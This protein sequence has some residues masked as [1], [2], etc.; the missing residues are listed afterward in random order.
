MAERARVV[1]AGGGI[2]GMEAALALREFA[3]E[4]A[5]VEIIDPAPSFTMPAT[6]PGRVVDL[7]AGGELPLDRVAEWAGATLHP[8]R[9]AAVDPGR[10]LAMLAGGE[11]LTYDVLVVATGA[12]AEPYIPDAITFTGHADVAKVRSLVDGI[13]HAAARGGRTDLAIVVPPGSAWPLAAYELAVLI[14]EHLVGLGHDSPG[15]TLVVTAEDGP[16]AVFGPEAS[17]AV[18]RWVDEAGVEV[19]TGAVVRSWRWGRIELAG[20]EPLQA[21]RMIALPVLRGPRLP[22]LPT[23][24]EGFVRSTPDGRIAG[25]EDVWVAGDA[26]SFPVKQGGIACQQA[27]AI[28]SAIARQLGAQ[29]EEVP[30]AP[31]LRGWVWDE[32]GG[33]F[34]RAELG[35]GRTESPGVAAGTPL[36]SPPAK[37]AGRFLAP[38]MRDLERGRPPGPAAQRPQ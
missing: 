13:A 11:L 25:V 7:V 21:D 15:R 1:I 37:V 33:R 26:G 36:W 31:V 38:F 5:R 34:L 12:R 24:A 27:D 2:A 30:F 23:D 18:G 17:D 14:R 9:L 19:L 8:A 16:L 29:A 32:E 6:A 10:H 28:A 20:G 22:E 35:G 4:R 3:G